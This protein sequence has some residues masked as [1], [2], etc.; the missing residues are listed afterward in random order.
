MTC[1]ANYTMLGPGVKQWLRRCLLCDGNRMLAGVGLGGGLRS[2]VWDVRR[3]T[4]P[5]PFQ[6]TI[7]KS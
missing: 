5:H 4:L 1:C 7:D 2:G 3:T 6:S